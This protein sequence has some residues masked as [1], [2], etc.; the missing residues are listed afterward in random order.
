MWDYV[1][2]RCKAREKDAN[3]LAE[4]QKFLLREAEIRQ[5]V[6]EDR[7]RYY[8]EKRDEW[9]EEYHRKQ[10]LLRHPNRQVRQHKRRCSDSFIKVNMLA[11][12]GDRINPVAENLET[13]FQHIKENP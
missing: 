7:M 3:L 5:K 6:T 12:Y 10:T 4:R 13:Y 9:L 8:K 2:K 1:E 11:I